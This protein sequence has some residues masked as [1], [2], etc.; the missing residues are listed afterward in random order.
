MRERSPSPLAE[1]GKKKA[2]SP[3]TPTTPLTTPYTAEQMDRAPELDEKKD[4]L[5]M[6]NLSHVS[7]QQRRGND[8]FSVQTHPTHYSALFTAALVIPCGKI[9]HSLSLS[10]VIYQVWRRGERKIKNKIKLDNIWRGG[11]TVCLLSPAKD[12][13]KTCMTFFLKGFKTNIF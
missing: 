1:R 7:P 5:L 2:S 13:H 12:R 8:L 10:F 4:F 11:Y 6:F 3:L 9:Q